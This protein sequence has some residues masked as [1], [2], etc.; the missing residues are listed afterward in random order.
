M[1]K[2]ET[3]IAPGVEITCIYTS[4]RSVGTYS[5]TYHKQEEEGGGKPALSYDCVTA[6]THT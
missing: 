4:E 6:C 1:A 5:P 3:E 2:E